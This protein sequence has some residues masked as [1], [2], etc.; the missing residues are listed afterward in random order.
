MKL[1]I[2][3]IIE[4]DLNA[5]L[6]VEQKPGRGYWFPFDEIKPDET[7]ALAA[8]RIANKVNIRFIPCHKLLIVYTL[9]QF[10]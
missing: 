1:V 6:L 5:L 9:D 2:C 8:K 4:R 7:R 10:I 3:V